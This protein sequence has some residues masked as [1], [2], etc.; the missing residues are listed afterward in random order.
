MKK[1]L[2]ALAFVLGGYVNAFSQAT[3]L[4]IDCQT[5]GWLSSMINYENQISLK[6]IKVTG[7]VNATDLNFIKR[8]NNNYSLSGV[9]DLEDVVTV[10]GGS[11][12]G[13]SLMPQKFMSGWK[14]LQKFIYPKSLIA[15]PYLAPDKS[16]KIDSIIWT[17][18]KVTELYLTW[19]NSDLSL[20]QP[21]NCDYIYLSDGVEEITEMPNNVKITFPKSLKKITEVG[22]NLTIYSF[23]DN[24]ESVYAERDFGY[25]TLNGYYHNYCATI[26]NSTF[27]IPK[28]TKEK[29]LNSDFATMKPYTGNGTVGSNNNVFIEYYDIDSTVVT[30]SLNM[31]VGDSLPL[32]VNIYPDDNLVSWINYISNAPE[33]VSVNPDGTIVAN[34]Y[35]GTEISVTPHVFIDGLET[36]SGKCVVNVVAHTEGVDVPSTMTV[37]I[38]ERKDLN[39]KTLPLDISDNQLLYESSD[40][41]VADVTEEGIIIGNKRG[42]CTITAT[43]VDGGYTATC[44]VTVTQPVEALTLEKHTLCM[45][46]GDTEKLLAQISPATADD[47]TIS[48]LS[49][50]DEIASVDANGNVSA[51]KA[52]EALI[53]AISN[54]N[55]EAKDSCKVIVLQPVT[56]IQLDNMTFQLNGIG[57]SF[58]LKATV[59]PDDASNKNIKWKSSDESVCVVSQGLVVAVGIGVCV[60]IATT[61][62]GGYMATCTVT[63]DNITGI[64]TVSLNDGQRFQVYDAKGS[65]QSHLQ[66]GVNIIRFVDGTKKKVIIK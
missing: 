49:S 21:S 57:E 66:K 11:I 43:A 64:S 53:K 59:V 28:G 35:G 42:K 3:S 31:Y 5:P 37:H 54:D 56:G 55:A 29:Y 36:K 47:K 46:V 30:P 13:D 40:H 19:F 7:Y 12:K 10:Q 41:F 1:K 58:E 20:N 62:D 33:I 14:H 17:S 26:I 51:Q 2:F 24:P 32:T 50:S 60:I 9:I 16:E 63:V 34:S 23:I 44:E 61:E 27:Y 15:Q 22:D 18:D 6:N 39:A 52:G 45:K 65:K 4:T 25:G 38:G 48:W 8:L